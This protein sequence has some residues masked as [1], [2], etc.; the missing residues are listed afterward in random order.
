[1]QSC[2]TLRV[3]ETPWK[4]CQSVEEMKRRATGKL[5]HS[6]LQ[7]TPI[8]RQKRQK[9][10]WHFWQSLSRSPKS[11]VKVKVDDWVFIKFIFPNHPPTPGKVSKKQYTAIYPKQKVLVY[12]R[13]LWKVFW[14]RRRPKD[15]LI[16]GK[17]V[18][19]IQ[20]I[21]CELKVNIPE[22]YNVP[23]SN[24]SLFNFQFQI[25]KFGIWKFGISKYRIWKFEI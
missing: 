23:I 25:F 5:L 12:V 4:S 18:R 8:L 19:N 1:M 16:R 6:K 20:L 11:K 15:D 7:L 13:R 22:K 21:F 10:K 2:W 3:D 24:V 17:K 9:Q 14:H